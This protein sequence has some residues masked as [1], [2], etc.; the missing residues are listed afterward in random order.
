MA[1]P[2]SRIDAAIDRIV[3]AASV[4]LEDNEAL[5]RR[6]AALHEAMTAAVAALDEQVARQDTNRIDA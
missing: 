3:A 2:A 5:R 4:C 1:D 6:H